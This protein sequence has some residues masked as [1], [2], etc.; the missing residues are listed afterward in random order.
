VNSYIIFGRYN[1][2]VNFNFNNKLA[3]PILF[4][5]LATVTSS[6]IA[7]QEMTLRDRLLLL[8]LMA[9]QRVKHIRAI[10][11]CF[12]LFCLWAKR[13]L[14]W[15]KVVYYWKRC[16]TPSRVTAFTNSFTGKNH[17]LLYCV[18]Q[19]VPSCMLHARTIMNWKIRV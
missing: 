12:A 1:T 3:I 13:C 4:S 16:G 10:D 17:Q 11:P 8:Q 9:A 5:L 15:W 19:R 18:I 2:L 6:A 14:V 7:A